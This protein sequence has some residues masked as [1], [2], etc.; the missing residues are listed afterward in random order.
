MPPL[1][2]LKQL[3][4]PT[5]AVKVRSMTDQ[6]QTL[7]PTDTSAAGPRPLAGIMDIAPYK[8][9]AAQADGHSRVL[10]LA[11]NES[12]YGPSPA[13]AEAF[14][15]QEGSL[16]RYPDGGAAI[17]Q[18][19][20][21]DAEGLNAENIVCS[22]G[23]D[24]LIALLTRAYAGPGDE[25]LYSAHGFLMYKLSTLASGATPIAVEEQDYTASID[26]LLNAV[27]PQTR[28]VYLANPN[29]PTGTVLSSQ[30]V[31]RL[32]A[33]LHPEILLVL[34]SA[35]A[36]YVTRSDYED[37]ARM[38]EQFSNVV[39]LRTFSKIHGLAS[40]RVG[41]AYAPPSVTAVLHRVRPPFNCTAPG[42]AAAAKAIGDKRHIGQVRTKTLATLA[43]FRE[44]VMAMGLDAPPSTGNFLLVLF[45]DREGQTA[46]AALAFLNSQGILVRPMGA[47][48]LP[49][50]LRITIGT[51]S[52]MDEVAAALSEFCETTGI[53]G[54]EESAREAASV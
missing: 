49:H 46:D 53:I 45:P 16:E 22:N 12:P 11:S 28:I 25:V 3:Q 34:D 48:A 10:R 52:E 43:R 18:H 13:A 24:E 32:H 19:A 36:E 27:T 44:E 39:M 29:N 35:Y 14:R 26:A 8:G 7:S 50:A 30:E 21:A 42:Q 37:G 40:V 2:H 15:A 5:R 4:P 9:G 47:Y 20:I 41:W 31:R 1:A 51:D 33:G 6:T 23:S 17:L 54:S 38:V